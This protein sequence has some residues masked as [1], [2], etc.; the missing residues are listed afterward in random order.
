MTYVSIP[1]DALLSVLGEKKKK[2]KKGKPP[3]NNSFLPHHVKKVSGRCRIFI[4]SCHV[5]FY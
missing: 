2:K 5:R 4:L 1:D 3:I